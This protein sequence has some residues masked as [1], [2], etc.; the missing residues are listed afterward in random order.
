MW[1]K[2]VA[3]IVSVMNVY[4]F[5]N[6]DEINTTVETDWTAQHISVRN[7]INLYE[8][9]LCSSL[10][11]CK[12]M[13]HSAFHCGHFYY[14]SLSSS[15]QLRPQFSSVWCQ[16]FFIRFASR[17]RRVKEINFGCRYILLNIL[18]WTT[19]WLYDWVEPGIICNPMNESVLGVS[20]YYVIHWIYFGVQRY[21]TDCCSSG[22]Q[23]IF[24]YIFNDLFVVERR[25][26]VSCH[27]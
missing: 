19:N 22:Q 3:V 15:L 26:A 9:C 10:T 18:N 14:T 8:S 5:W 7:S 11:H 1:K 17:L 6:T 16:S 2:T 27:W 20:C 12:L 23:T 4:V 24:I 13:L 25:R 21:W